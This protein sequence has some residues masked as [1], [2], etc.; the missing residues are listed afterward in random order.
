[1]KVYVIESVR[2]SISFYVEVGDTKRELVKF[3]GDGNGYVG[4]STSNKK[5]IKGIENSDLFKN[6]EIKLVSSIEESNDNLNSENGNQGD[7]KEYPE[8]TNLQEA[9]E[10]LRS[11]YNIP[12]QSLGSQDNILKKAIEVGASFPNLQVE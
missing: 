6:G 12:H 8:V 3:T 7:L 4:Y 5:I 10:L 11:E 1:M 2:N 9:K